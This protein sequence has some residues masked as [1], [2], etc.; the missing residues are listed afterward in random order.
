MSQVLDSR[1]GERVVFGVFNTQ[2][3]SIVGS[4]V[5]SFRMSDIRDSFNGAFKAQRDVNSNWLP[6]AK[7]QVPATRPGSCRINSESLDEEHLN[8]LKENTLMDQAV[9]SSINMPH[10]IKTSP[11]ERLTTIAVDPSVPTSGGETVDVL[12]VGTTRGRVLKMVSYQ[13]GGVPETTLVEELQ[14]FPLHVSVSN[15]QIVR[16]G[17]EPRVVVLS[18]HEV[19]SL[20]VERCHST[21]IQSCGACV[22][23]QDPYCAWNVK[24]QRCYRLEGSTDD[25]SSL[26]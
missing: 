12:F 1:T 13:Y 19:K 10:F 26:P 9:P 7:Q 6:L 14:V 8:F 23:M 17:A 15:I 2:E 11:H 22:A 20:P 5:C 16:S 21:N 4:A 24:S 25:S 18:K 3:N